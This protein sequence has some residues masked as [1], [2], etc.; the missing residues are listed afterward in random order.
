MRV[1]GQLARTEKTCRNS[2]SL[3]TFFACS[4]KLGL[5]FTLKVRLYIKGIFIPVGI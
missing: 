1:I 2:L 3:E 4:F 5:N